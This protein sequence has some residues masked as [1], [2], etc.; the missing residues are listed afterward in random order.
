MWSWQKS[1]PGQHNQHSNS[2]LL[3]VM[4]G[5]GNSRR[6]MKSPPLLVAAL[7]ACIIV[8]VFNYWIASSRS[9]DLQNRIM[10]L[11][12]R[13]RRAAVERGAVELKKNEFQGELKKQREQIDRIQSLHN[14]QME[15]TNKM[16]MDEKAVLL[17]NISVNDKLIQNLQG[18][19][20]E[21]QKEYGKLQLDVYRFQ[22]NQTNLQMKFTYDMSQ[23]INQMKELKEKCEEKI[24]EISKR[25]SEIPQNKEKTY[26]SNVLDKN[27]Q[28]PTFEQP[29][30]QQRDLTK[31]GNEPKLK[32]GNEIQE[33]H[34]SAG[35]L[36]SEALKPSPF[37][38]N[39][40][41]LDY[42]RGKDEPKKEEEELPSEQDH[43]Q[44]SAKL[45]PDLSQLPP[46][47]GKEQNPSEE[48]GNV[49]AGVTEERQASKVPEPL[50]HQ[51][52]KEANVEDEEVEREH[53]LNDDLQPD[54]QEIKKDGESENKKAKQDS[55][56]V[57]YNLEINEAESET[58]KE[59]AL[60]GNQN[61]LNVQN[62]E[63]PNLPNHLLKLGE[64]HQ[65]L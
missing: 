14:F 15:N 55:K 53:L 41:E 45:S 40:A 25:G 64:E 62:L 38:N 31:Q 17:N 36:K 21:L 46:E 63:D 22:K 54:D 51:N 57:D 18:Q 47:P 37:M 13:V 16:H 24:E 26:L 11:E 42:H 8:L 50:S 56:E 19:L 52:N 3:S 58:D 33:K 12:N 6:G 29:E 65:H 44:I 5:L 1:N 59:A 48:T 43:Q 60:V 35:S 28:V 9:V 10:E 27:V 61:N 39:V 34:I 4:V 23:C 20:K 30:F 2:Y 32:Q 49:L 7:V